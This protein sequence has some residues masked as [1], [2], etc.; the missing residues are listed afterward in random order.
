[1]AFR[2]N[3]TNE[4]LFVKQEYFSIPLTISV[5]RNTIPKWRLEILPC[6]CIYLKRILSLLTFDY[7]KKG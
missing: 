1:M 2:N 6:L 7:P 3:D 4:I 5:V